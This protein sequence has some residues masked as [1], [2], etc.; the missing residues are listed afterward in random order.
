MG[1]RVLL[2]RN[3]AVCAWSG[4]VDG[5]RYCIQ[6]PRTTTWHLLKCAEIDKTW[7]AYALFRPR[8]KCSQ[9]GCEYSQRRWGLTSPDVNIFDPDR[10]ITSPDE[11]LT[12]PDVNIPEPDGGIPGPD[13]KIP[14]PDEGLTGPDVTISVSHGGLL[15]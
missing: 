8:C 2:A 15:A 3:A 13:E 6:M 1:S 14:G 10:G 7:P 12:D 9:P 5:A 4:T 11:G